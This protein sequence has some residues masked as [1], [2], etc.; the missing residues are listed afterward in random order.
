MEFQN[1]TAANTLHPVF[2]MSKFGRVVYANIPGMD[3]MDHLE[4]NIGDKVYA[5]I[6]KHAMASFSTSIFMLS[7][8]RMNYKWKLKVL[9][10]GLVYVQAKPESE[11]NLLFTRE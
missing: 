8:R 2:I 6:W 7:V 9:H 3:I 4:L 1:L 5:Q 10:S 11:S